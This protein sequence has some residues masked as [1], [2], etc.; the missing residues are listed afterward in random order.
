MHYGLDIGGTKIEIAVFNHNYIVQSTQRIP[1]PTSDYQVFF[2]AIKALIEQADRDNNT[3]GSVG[4]GFP[5]VL[6]PNTGRLLSSNIPCANGMSLKHD[7][8]NHLQR[9]VAVENDCRCFTYSEASGGA[10]DQYTRV[11]GAILGTGI[12]GGFCIERKIYSG[13]Q[14]VSGEWG[15]IPISAAIQQ[16]YQLPLFDCGC[17]LSGCVERYIAGPG[18]A[19]LY[20][21][22][23][24]EKISTPEIIERYRQGEKTAEK[25]FHTFID[26]AAAAMS[27]L[28]FTFDPDAIVV[29]GGLSRV[30]ELYEQLP[31][32][33]K[34]YLFGNLAP[35]AILPPAHGDSSG[36]RGAAILGTDLGII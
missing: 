4:I 5:G 19:R 29:G 33:M 24:G 3:Q 26:I 1:T 23:G 30:P 7:L 8:E 16:K 10:A 12:G 18:V 35:P 14:Q 2:D 13:A 22:Y 34:P 11:F 25:T 36:V 20:H 27:T 6:N 15:H 9:S 31:E 17:G 28:V 32:A 21:F